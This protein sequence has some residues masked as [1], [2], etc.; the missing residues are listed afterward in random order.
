MHL[1]QRPDGPLT[2]DSTRTSLERQQPGDPVRQGG[3]QAAP[4]RD[5]LPAA[6]AGLRDQR[7]R[8]PAP[9]RPAG[10]GPAGP[11]WRSTSPTGS[12]SSSA[13]TSTTGSTGPP[14]GC[15][16]SGPST[17][18]CTSS[19]PT[20]G[21]CTLGGT[22]GQLGAT[23]CDRCA[24]GGPAVRQ[25]PYLSPWITIEGDDRRPL[26]PIAL[27]QL[28]PRRPGPLGDDRRVARARP[29]GLQPVHHLAQRR[30][31]PQ[32]ERPPV[33]RHLHRRRAASCTT[34]S[35]ISSRRR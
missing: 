4:L 27:G 8:L 9:G 13:G 33:L 25:D 21:G 22:L 1:Y 24:R 5:R 7:H 2:F 12:S 19:S 29:Q 20:A 32:P 15:P 26:V 6:H 16:P 17:P 3:R 30:V 31:Q 23:Y 14:R 35:R 11:T 10:S 34:P 28:H 18:T